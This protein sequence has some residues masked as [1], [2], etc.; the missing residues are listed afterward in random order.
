MRTLLHDGRFALRLLIKRPGF[1]AVAI[2]TLALGIG[3]TTAIFTVVHA[4]L[5]SPLPFRDADRLV[6]VRIAGAD[7]Q[8]YPLPDA[9]FVAW[10]D[11]NQTADA[12]AVWSVDAATLTG[13]GAAERIGTAFVTDRF[14]DVLG[15]R[16]ILGRVFHE[17]D[18]QPAAPKTI[19][20]SEPFWSRRFH[21]D[22][23]V[24]GST[25]A[26]GGVEIGRAHV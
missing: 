15:A 19:V 22:P 2:V 24:V 21:R 25:L 6:A 12:I 8:M 16:P 14:F 20:L 9:D 26:L 17:G 7:N 10:R 5:L 4:I 13:D 3:A 1:S 11:Q 23:N 18:D